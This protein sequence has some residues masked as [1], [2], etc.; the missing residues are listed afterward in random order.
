[1]LIPCRDLV[2]APFEPESKPMFV[3]GLFRDKVGMPR[4]KRL[5][6]IL[7]TVKVLQLRLYTPKL[8]TVIVSLWINI[9][10]MRR[11][12]FLSSLSLEETLARFLL[13]SSFP[14]LGRFS[15]LLFFAV[16]AV[17][18]ILFLD[19]CACWCLSFSENRGAILSFIARPKVGCDKTENFKRFSVEY[20][21]MGSGLHRSP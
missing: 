8:L 7:I 14:S 5:D 11:L 4:A 2:A 13:R 15:F 9:H 20:Y 6:V 19:V 21:E 12:R 17:L 18:R 3:W 10:L 16:C 1:M